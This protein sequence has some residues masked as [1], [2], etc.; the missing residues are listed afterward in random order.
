LRQLL[1]LEEQHSDK[2][3]QHIGWRLMMDRKGSGIDMQFPIGPG[4][5]QAT[6]LVS[7]L[8]HY[9]NIICIQ[10]LEPSIWKC[11]F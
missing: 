9:V 4:A 2:L 10:C 5:T 1:L 8:F 6:L 7:G 3:S 11:L